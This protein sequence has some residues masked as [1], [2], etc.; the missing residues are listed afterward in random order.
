MLKNYQGRKYTSLKKSKALMFRIKCLNKLLP[1]HD[2]CYQRRPRLY[3]GKTCIACYR[4]EEIFNHLA[5]CEIYQK[6][7]KHT[8]E[9]IIEELRHKIIKE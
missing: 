7:W 1:T 5:V 8:E 9:I 3:K 2:I 4:T 6:I